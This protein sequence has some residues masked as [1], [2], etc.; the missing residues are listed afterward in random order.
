MS[1]KLIDATVISSTQILAT[2]TEYLSSNIT[3]NTISL[4]SEASSVANP[5]ILSF[6]IYQNQL[7]ITTQPLKPFKKY[8]LSFTNDG[9]FTS[10]NGSLYLQNDG[11]SKVTI[12]GPIQ[13]DDAFF[14]SFK[15]TFKDNY[16]LNDTSGVLY[17]I[18]S[19]YSNQLSK[20]YHNVKSLVNDNYLTFDVVDELKVRGTGAYDRLNEENAYELLR[21]S[22]NKT[23]ALIFEIVSLNGKNAV[24][25]LSASSISES[26]QLETKDFLGS[27]NL[28]TFTIN[29]TFPNVIS[30]KSLTIDYTDGSS[31]EYNIEKY[32]Y[33]LLT[34]KYDTLNASSNKSL[35]NN[36]IKLN[37]NEMSSVSFSNVLRVNIFY[38]YNKLGKRIDLNTVSVYSIEKSNRE[39]P[40]ALVNKFTLS[41][42]F[43]TNSFG[44]KITLSGLII[45]GLEEYTN[46]THP[47]F[48]YEIPF[49]LDALPNTPG[50][51]CVDYNAGDV[52]VYGSDTNKQGT[53][54]NPP[55]ISFYYKEIYNKETD[56]ALN[57]SSIDYS[58][59]NDLVI[60]P[61]SNLFVNKINYYV[62]FFYELN[63]VLGDDFKALFHNESINEFVNNNLVTP[64]KVKTT[65]EPITNVFRV[66]NQTTGEI[67]NVESFDDT[68]IS[69]T[70]SNL[71][72][73]I[74]ITQERV[75]FEQ[76]NNELILVDVHLVNSS[77]IN[78]FKI[79]LDT[80]LIVSSTD[81]SVGSL[82]NTSVSFSNTS[83]FNEE[84][85]YTS[86]NDLDVG[87]YS[88]DYNTGTIYV[89]VDN[90]NDYDL[91]FVSYKSNKVKTNN[92]HIITVDS[93]YFKNTTTSSREYDS[94]T[95]YLIVTK[96]IP[97]SAEFYFSTN[98]TYQIYN[99]K[100]GAFL[101]SSFN[102][103]VSGDVFGLN[104]VYEYKDYTHSKKPLNFAEASLFAD[105]T[106]TTNSISKSFIETVASDGYMYVQVPFELQYVSSDID[107]SISIKRIYDDV[108]FWDISGTIV[109]GNMVRFN[110][111]GV[112]S[113]TQG[114]VVRV[115]LNITINDLSRV[116]VDYLKGN[117]LVDY[118]Y[119]ADE[120]LVSYE[121]G[122]NVL[123]FSESNSILSGDEYYVSYRV[124]ALRNSL[125]NN[126][127]T[128][129]GIDDLINF[130]LDINRENYRDILL[131]GMTSFIKG[132]TSSAIENIAQKISHLPAKV[133]EGLFNQWSLGSS[134]LQKSKPIT[135]KQEK[136]VPGKFGQAL[137]FTDQSLVVKSHGNFSS[138][139]GTF[140]A[141]VN[142]NWF[143]IDSSANVEFTVLRDGY[144]VDENSIFIGALEQHPSSHIFTLNKS[145]FDYYFEPNKNKD[146]VYIYHLNN[147]WNVHVIDGYTDGYAVSHGYTITMKTNGLYYNVITNGT[148]TTINNTLKLVTPT[149][150]FVN[151]TLSFYCDVNHYILDIP[152]DDSHFSLYKDTNGY[153]V[154]YIKD[155]L[156]NTYKLSENISSWKYGDYHLVGISWKLN[157][158]ESK[159]FMRLFVDGKQVANK[160]QYGQKQLTFENPFARDLG[161][162]PFIN[163]T[164]YD[165]VGSIDLQ[166]TSG[167][168]QVTSSIN[169]SS[170]NISAGNTIYIYESG[171]NPSGYT[172]SSVVGQT[173]VLS[174]NMP[175]TVSGAHFSV[176]PIEHATNAKLDTYGRFSVSRIP[177]SDV[178]SID[179]I[180][181]L[182]ISTFNL[183]TSGYQKGDYLYLQS[184]FYEL[185]SVDGYYATVNK[186]T[187][188]GSGKFY[189][190]SDEVELSGLKALRPD[191]SFD[192]TLT[193][194]NNVYANDLLYVK[195]YGLNHKYMYADSYVWAD[196]YTSSLL[197]KLKSPIS[198]DDLFIQKTLLNT[199]SV[200]S[201]NS[202]V[203]GSVYTFTSTTSQPILT[204]LGRTLSAKV[205]SNNIDFS[206]CTMYVDGYVG[207]T[208]ITETLTFTENGVLDTSNKYTSI[209]GIT[210]TCKVVN[211]SLP[212]GNI[213]VFE[214]YN[215]TQA[216]L[217]SAP[218][219][220]YAYVMKSNEDVSISGNEVT[221]NTLF[222]SYDVGN[223]FVK[224]APTY[225]QYKIA[226]VS[227]DKTKITIT[228]L[229]GSSVS[230]TESSVRYFILNNT[231]YSAGL[232]N[233]FIYLL[234][235]NS[236]YYLTKGLYKISYPTYLDIHFTDESNMYIGNAYDG[237]KPFMG[238][239]ERVKLL[240]IALDDVRIGE[241]SSVIN[242]TSE[243][244]KI[245]GLQKESNTLCYL[246]LD[247]SIEDTSDFYIRYIKKNESS[248]YKPGVN[249]DASL[250]IRDGML[251]QDTGLTNKIGAVEFWYSPMFDTRNDPNERYFFDTSSDLSEEVISVTKSTLQLSKP[252]KQIKSIKVVGSDFEYASGSFLTNDAQNTSQEQVVSLTSSSLIISNPTL[253]VTSIRVIG[254]RTNKEYAFGA[255]LDADKRTIFLA[256][257]L[258]QSNTPLIVAYKP[259]NAKVTNK[260]IV[261][262]NKQLPGENTLVKVMYT[263]INSQGDRLSLFKDKYGMLNFK[264]IGSNIETSIQVPISW[265]KGTWHRIRASYKFNS[266]DY[267]L[268]LWVDGYE[269]INNTLDQVTVDGYIGY[270]SGV[271]NTNNIAYK[272]QIND[273]FIG[274][275]IYQN[276]VA[277]GLINNLRISN[278][279]RDGL[280]YL[281]ENLDPNFSKNTNSAYPV[282]KD[283]YT[284]YLLEGLYKLAQSTDVAILA[285]AITSS[286][287]FSLIV[288]DQL[289]ML[290]SYD[291]LKDILSQLV[292]RLKPAN[293]KVFFEYK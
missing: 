102:N 239:I 209:A 233:G 207:A 290:S 98:F 220:N 122:D 34:N 249:F 187:D 244:N 189:K 284:T 165:T 134:F 252:A 67:Y 45:E 20:A 59:L 198:L 262:L 279:T 13:E 30:L 240:N 94:F 214:K 163:T 196:G 111:S 200:T 136:Y 227:D 22:K 186:I 271:G 269:R 162:D 92:N 197:T 228:E 145:N 226:S 148:T 143:G 139:E 109:P 263:P 113:P 291:I 218:T 23:N 2:F 52:Y 190:R 9:S 201:L 19:G 158:P 16:D 138:Q 70:G 78:V 88:I 101:E 245:K 160:I 272:D 56:Y 150:L 171:F 176:N 100:I 95:D 154:F 17:K 193:L 65:Y 64:T 21:V 251:L 50:Q 1:L 246:T 277:S 206:N 84:L 83:V 15:N 3:A 12:I 149:S 172:I 18:F 260:Q 147:Q 37:I 68:T 152:G 49:N 202:S 96:N 256:S 62:D 253:Q 280:Y 72:K 51:F 40:P 4:V 27:L 25:S 66:Y 126:F 142:P 144:G 293:S 250:V 26:L 235:D 141:W 55:V 112:N 210:F 225:K 132:P 270:Y 85:F 97:Q 71:P 283:V 219:V 117:L 7:T 119:L 86:I 243:F 184:K 79:K 222:S 288:H 151:C 123:D 155:K 54:L 47:A 164:L 188:S 120:L 166:T 75:S 39:L 69:F 140:E 268:R 127:A 254:D 281:S 167:S 107:Y 61:E 46:K 35:L 178:T 289:Q 157:S 58:G 174:S 156:N 36:Q 93:L 191:Y 211:T 57:E 267:G 248:D 10:E 221:D 231:D 6:D 129:L 247:G 133:V 204:S 116:C 91:G 131:A 208:H 173:L 266:K 234:K 168:N 77:L 104:G 161:E 41:H 110:L 53:G 229:D 255:V 90:S 106:I 130:S 203:L 11:L 264:A 181:G 135:L 223:I 99:N 29:A 265:K 48:A 14:A 282:L 33:S 232:Q 213:S 275:D 259:I 257:V 146:G 175:Y 115:E 169:F 108:E 5:K 42:P 8:V 287:D 205:Y 153:L 32:G 137:D 87:Q 121:Y 292:N 128:T 224:T 170:F 74:S 212:A 103:S 124:G 192:Q 38:D 195:T 24:S 230:I 73:L 89:A 258:P 177:V 285:N 118:T 217:D 179:I 276:N 159:D 185:H 236:P 183:T 278:N 238:S 76:I 274:S 261:V 43:I 180:D 114:D 125:E 182:V 216:E 273:V 199:T 44:G 31:Y 242:A 237:S 80:D 28:Q 241:T 63:Y 82:T 60:L 286:N 194:T 215:V 81:D 105:K